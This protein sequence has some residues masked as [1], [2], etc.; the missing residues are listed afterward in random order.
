MDDTL[1]QTWARRPIWQNELTSLLNSTIR[2]PP[3]TQATSVHSQLAS[4][5]DCSSQGHAFWIL[6]S[7]NNIQSHLLTIVWQL[8]SWSSRPLV[9]ILAQF[10]YVS[11]AWQDVWFVHK[12]NEKQDVN[13][14][15]NPQ[16]IFSFC[17]ANKVKVSLPMRKLLH[18]T[19]LR[20]W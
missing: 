20:T 12:F 3:S 19:E 7:S 1:Q 5:L 9:S 2:K 16:V 15:F 18:H 13:W 11:E 17:C 8:V 10:T 14:I 4:I 6:V